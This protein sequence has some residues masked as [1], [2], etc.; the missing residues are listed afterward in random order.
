MGTVLPVLR[1]LMKFSK[2]AGGCFSQ[3]RPGFNGTAHEY[4]GMKY[5]RYCRVGTK[6]LQ[7]SFLSISVHLFIAF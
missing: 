4:T 1:G 3:L 2:A 6:A 7:R 5:N